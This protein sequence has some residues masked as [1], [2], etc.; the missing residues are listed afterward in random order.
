MKKGHWEFAFRYE[1]KRPP[2]SP[3]KEKHTIC[4]PSSLY[5]PKQ[6]K[7]THQRGKMQAEKGEH[8]IVGCGKWGMRKCVNMHSI[9]LL[10]T[11]SRLFWTNTI[12]KSFFTS[13]IEFEFS[14]CAKMTVTASKLKAMSIC[15]F[16][17]D[18]NLKTESVFTHECDKN[19]INPPSK[20]NSNSKW[21][22]ASQL[23]QHGLIQGERRNNS[24]VS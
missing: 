12:W 5:V 6:E 23:W 21:F 3:V 11:T 8:G 16:P 24:A 14:N 10:S 18:V 4:K 19:P 22:K 7:L 15:I 1:I 20:P 9:N 13:D 2:S 17:A